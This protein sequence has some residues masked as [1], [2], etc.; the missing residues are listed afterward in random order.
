M[1]RR[2]NHAPTNA[3][4]LA[5][6]NTPKRWPLLGILPLKRTTDDGTR[7]SAYMKATDN[8]PIIYRGNINDTHDTDRAE[9]FATFDAII[10]AGWRVD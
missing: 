6:I 1:T 8:A 5:F 10:A 2:K 9:H 3:D 4:H 7:E